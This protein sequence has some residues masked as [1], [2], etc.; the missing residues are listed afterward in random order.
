MPLKSTINNTNAQKENI[1]TVATQIDNKLVELGGE[2]ATNL[3]DVVSKMGAMVGQYK[4]IAIGN[5][6]NFS[7]SSG[8]INE[9]KINMNLDFTPEIIF[10]NVWRLSLFERDR[11]CG[12]ADS[13]Y[14][15][16]DGNDEINDELV[17]TYFAEFKIKEGSISKNDF[18]LNLAPH[19]SN[20]DFA[21]AWIAIG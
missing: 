1:K 14:N 12:T 4:K 16:N 2:K 13:R 20:R 17:N 7:V 3:S 18:T 10:C 19:S 21:I 15:I 6:T 11:L 8:R 9:L 5:K